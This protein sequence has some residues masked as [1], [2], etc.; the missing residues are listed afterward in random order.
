MSPAEIKSGNY[1]Q[2]LTPRKELAV[3]LA[4]RGHCLQDNGRL[5]E[6]LVAYAQANQL[7]PKNPVYGYF[8][9]EA[10]M[11]RPDMQAMVAKRV[12]KVRTIDRFQSTNQT[13]LRAAQKPWQ[14]PSQTSQN[15]GPPNAQAPHQTGY[16][17]PNAWNDDA[18]ND[19]WNDDANTYQP[20]IPTPFPN[21]HSQLP[22]GN[23]GF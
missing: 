8:L 21:P 19:A 18:R 6:C 16:Q 7:A 4:A 1:L 14:S 23:P 11:Q 13:R 10:M 2:S 15:F 9:T 12:S 22:Q 17:P 20:G 5:D 3:F